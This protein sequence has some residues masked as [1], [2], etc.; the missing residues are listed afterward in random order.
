MG[1]RVKNESRMAD[2]RLGRKIHQIDNL[3]KDKLADYAEMY[4]RGSQRKFDTPMISVNFFGR[5]VVATFSF[6]F[7]KTK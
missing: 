5:R 6:T 1:S 4:K 7:A 2:Q 3:L